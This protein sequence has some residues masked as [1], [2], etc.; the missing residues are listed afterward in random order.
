MSTGTGMSELL[1]A[2]ERALPERPIG[3]ALA[4]LAATSGVDA[5]RLAALSLGQRDRLLF[6]LRER[7]F[8]TRLAS[9]AG[10]PSCA[11]TVE[12][13]FD[14]RDLLAAADA[15]AAAAPA[16]PAEPH[17]AASDGDG[18]A[19]RRLVVGEYEV[20]YRCLTS[21]D[22]L[23]AG[24]LAEA[25][26]ARDGLLER[27]VLR[28][29]RANEPLAAR[30]LPAPVR[31]ALA[32]AMAAADPQ[33]DLQINLSCKACGAVW[34]TAFDVVGYLWSEIDAWAQRML[35]EI[36]TLALRYGWSESAILS[37]STRRRQTYL[38]FGDA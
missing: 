12:F 13:S 29:L 24:T 9:L 4:L 11:E 22:L 30:E 1:D 10:C 27:C 6:G 31:D 8:G 21:A 36:H 18:G 28:A 3:R 16:A 17:A 15:D 23:A 37:M 14:T 2:W 5:D 19:A 38:S 26:A 33:A 20:V 32:D 35:A 7:L 25:D 34:Q